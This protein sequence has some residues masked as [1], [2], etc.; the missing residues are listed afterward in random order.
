MF[1][2]KF[3]GNLRDPASQRRNLANL[4]STPNRRSLRFELLENRLLLAADFGDAP[5]PYPTLLANNGARHEAVGPTLGILRDSESDG[6]P[7]SMA[8][9][10][11]SNPEMGASDEDGVTFGSI[12]VGQL[13]ASVVVNVQNAPS[14]ARLDAWIDF[15]GDGN[16]GGAWER[17]ANGLLV[18]DGNNIVTFDVP[19]DARSG[20]TVARFRLSTDGIN[21]PEGQANDGEIEDHAVTILPPNPGSGE[22]SG[23]QVI[24]SSSANATDLYPVDLDRDGDMD[25]VATLVFNGKLLWYENNGN[26]QF[27]ERGL[28][29]PA[30]GDDAVVAVDFDADNDL[31]II[32]ADQFSD[33]ILLFRNN[34]NQQFTRSFLSNAADSPI[35]LS[36]A[37]VDGDGDPDVLSASRLDGRVYWH[38]NV[39]GQSVVSRVLPGSESG[40][41][42]VLAADLDNDGDMDIVA[43]ASNLQ[44]VVDN[45]A[46]VWFEN[47]G[48][49][50]FTKH[51]ITEAALGVY[52]ISIADIDQDGDL[53]ISSASYADNT[54]A[55]YENDGAQAFTQRTITSAALVAEAVEAVD[56]DGDG[57]ID[58]LALAETTTGES[59]VRWYENNGSQLF[60]ERTIGLTGTYSNN[61]YAVD[62]DGD[63]DV[64]VLT[65]SVNTSPIGWFRQFDYIIS[66]S[67]DVTHIEE[68]SN[69]P[70]TVTFRRT[71]RLAESLSL[72]F[73]VNG[74]AQFQQDYLQSG[75]SSFTATS[76]TVLFNTEDDTASVILTSI[77]DD[78][79]EHHENINISIPSMW[80]KYLIVDEGEV[81]I[82][83]LNDEPSD[84]GDAPIPYSTSDSNSGPLHG[85]SGP[86]LGNLRDE[87]SD[88]TP[89]LGADYDNL[90]GL[91]DEDGV[92]VDVIRVGQPRAVITVDVTNAPLGARLDAWIDFNADGKWNGPSEQIANNLLVHEGV[93]YVS[94]NVP[95]DAL[96]GTTFGRFR[97]SSSGE[98]T[99]TSVAID[100]EI[101]DH[102]ITLLPPKAEAGIFGAGRIISDLDGP[103]EIA[104]ADIDRDGDLD[105]FGAFYD[106]IG[107]SRL[108]WY[109]NIAFDSYVEHTIDSFYVL[110]PISIEVADMDGD[111]NE[112]LVVAI[113]RT[114]NDSI[115]VYRNNG[116]GSFTKQQIGDT[117]HT[118]SQI[119]VGDIDG[120]GDFDLFVISQESDMIERFENTG[121]L[122]FV[123]K[124][125][126][127]TL[128]APDALSLVDLD[129]DGDLDVLVSHY[130]NKLVWYEQ[131]EPLRFSA[132][133]VIDTSTTDI[134]WTQPVDIDHDGDM[135]IVC[136]GAYGLFWFQNDGQQ[137]FVRHVIDTSLRQVRSVYVAD[138]N[139]DGFLDVLAGDDS[140]VVL[141]WNDGLQQFTE[142]AI[143]NSAHYV[144]SVIAA[145]ADGDGDLDIIA[146]EYNGDTIAW[147]EH[148]GTIVAVMATSTAVTED[149][150][151]VLKV[152]FERSGSDLSELTVS[153]TVGGSATFQSD[154]L[155]EGT[156]TFTPTHGSALFGSGEISTEVTIIPI[157][158]LP[159]EMDE[160]VII[161][162]IAGQHYVQ[163]Q[164]SSVTLTI[165]E[166]GTLDFGDA[167]T[168]YRTSWSQGGAH[169]G[170]VGPRLGASRDS[171]SDGQPSSNADSD[172]SDGIDDEDGAAFSVIRAGQ[173]SAA[174]TVNVQNAPAGARLDAWFD[175]NGDGTW[176]GASEQIANDLAVVEGDNLVTFSVPSDARL[177]ETYVR[178]RLSSEGNLNVTGL[179]ADGEVE[180]YLVPIEPPLESSGF[181]GVPSVL[182][183]S[184][185]NAR[186]LQTVD[187][188]RDGDWD[189]L[190]AVGNS[191]LWYENSGTAEF[192]LHTLSTTVSNGRSIHA[193]DLDCDDD[194]DILLASPGSSTIVAFVNNGMH[195]FTRVTLANS[196]SGASGV[197]A[198]YPIDMDSDGDSD[199]VSIASG[200]NLV[201]YENSGT[202][203]FTPRSISTSVRDSVAVYA[204]DLDH[205]GDVDIVSGRTS[206]NGLAWYEN[207]GDQTFTVRTLGS[208]GSFLQL[209]SLQI[210]DLNGDGNLDILYSTVPTFSFSTGTTGWFE[211]NGDRTFSLHEIAPLSAGA[212]QVFAADMDGDGDLDVLA[213]RNLE[214]VLVWYENDGDAEFAPQV[215]TTGNL[216]LSV[217]PVD[218]D[219][220]GDLDVVAGISNSI[221]L[222]DNLNVIPASGDYDHNGVTDEF[223]YALWKSNF[224]STFDRRPDGNG[225]NRI[226]AADFVVW[227]DSYG[228]TNIEGATNQGSTTRG[229]EGRE[230]LSGEDL[231]AVA[232][233]GSAAIPIAIGE[234]VSNVP[235]GIVSEL[236]TGPKSAANRKFARS[237][238]ESP[239][240]LDEDILLLLASWIVES[241]HD[242]EHALKFK[243][244][245]D[246]VLVTRVKTTSKMSLA[247]PFLRDPQNSLAMLPLVLI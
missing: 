51:L 228:G 106:P 90:N 87:E 26:A 240:K 199:F 110:N 239:T 18:I 47:N 50:N 245:E 88:G 160:S 220:D 210:V 153:F 168:S 107:I 75:A 170:D 6:L 194:F 23:I 114:G 137:S 76:G 192:T 229:S 154:Y 56:M 212:Q 95:A 42:N 116:D 80:P 232:E 62:M 144:Q 188:D 100:G 38:E 224:G 215:L 121:G 162:L 216:A 236:F 97:L 223:D 193:V 10:D 207:N 186:S 183:P 78:Q 77:A 145:D 36:V 58:V 19:V 159:F 158:D 1:R 120:D 3:K 61:V 175:F 227:R 242:G 22:F 218:V 68:D 141:F 185:A 243:Y 152:R 105:L 49:Q 150:G 241:E 32:T 85:A 119:S 46:I 204:A 182:N 196:S 142:Q 174:I 101:E 73:S 28:G 201:W 128:D 83:L 89:S 125:F 176:M 84:Y 148:V 235:L 45:N 34:G 177:G 21:S 24:T 60:T 171:E 52:S 99:P 221:V 72:P 66:V 247:L 108:S 33:E 222:L 167:P 69:Y 129:R 140:N 198:L 57:D 104:S 27:T 191:V 64:D 16:W 143:N 211:N 133:K 54:I 31:D 233:G 178:L 35:D 184:A 206:F 214:N 7:S 164:E 136:G 151:D 9:G 138:I 41:K 213:T 173:A 4:Q 98:L 20:S 17:I 118:V 70:V 53:D 179:A 113:R 48:S 127:S 155:Q 8:N 149:G 93:N 226:N 205:D 37:D 165:I 65:E 25:V 71:G 234:E 146:A 123:K 11:D 134:L 147:Y 63:G 157:G 217:I 43:S 190:A 55:W 203:Q 200:G 112:D 13:G 12:R 115:C 181:F 139:G 74:R 124:I 92:Q 131:R 209:T 44:L 189:L 156:A 244:Y 94:F 132:P 29:I 237:L 91:D 169:H 5:A 30:G 81:D 126:S 166:D 111:G 79:A 117:E 208:T 172:D 14:G 59:I 197:Q 246:D 238:G 67:A 219:A 225:D 15:N 39:D 180:D 86:I 187:L 130:F 135:D 103:K 40:I 96:P 102:S 161:T 2:N 109:E 202:L 230:D 163:V 122:T 195:E 231:V 82:V